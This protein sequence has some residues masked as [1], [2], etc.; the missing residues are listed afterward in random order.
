[1]RR[2]LVLCLAMFTVAC[3]QHP[4]ETLQGY[5]EAD[6]VYLSSQDPGIIGELFVREGDTV[7][8]GAPVFRLDPQRLGYEAHSAASQQAASDNAIHT[9]QANAV[10]AERNYARGTELAAQ[11]FYPR[12]RLDAD[13]AA[14]DVANAQLAQARRQAA[15]AGAQTGL[16]RERVHDT[17]TRAPAA[18]TIEQIFHRPGEVVAAGAPIVALLPPQ[19]MKV[20]F[21]APQAMLARLPVGT[22][23]A[24]SCDG[25]AHPFAGRVSFVAQEPQFTPP[26]IYSL[27]QREKL[28][29]LI[30]A[31]FDAPTTIRPGVPV[32]VRLAQ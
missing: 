18:G 14:R 10:L 23:V 1:M 30:E 7:A 8:A 17:S 13:R 21:F 11:G 16:A 20:R 4:S 19:N 28:V 3:T 22:H 5:G 2:L 9:A 24:V 27:D 31:R 25:C 32:D 29:F 15:A 12:A 26:V 6:Y